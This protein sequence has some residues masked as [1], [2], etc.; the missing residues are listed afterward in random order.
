MWDI[1]SGCNVI[2]TFTVHISP[3][4]RPPQRVLL[5]VEPTDYLWF[6]HMSSWTRDETSMTCFQD[7]A[8]SSCLVGSDHGV[9]Q[10]PLLF[11]SENQKKCPWKQ[12]KLY[13]Q[14]LGYSRIF[15]QKMTTQRPNPD[16]R[17]L[18]GAVSIGAGYQLPG[19]RVQLWWPRHRS[20]GREKHKGLKVRGFSQLKM[21]IFH[22]YVSLPEGKYNK[23]WLVVWSMIFIFFHLLGISSSQL[24]NS[25]FS[26]G[27][28]PPT[29]FEFQ[30]IFSMGAKAIQLQLGQFAGAF[31]SWIR[32]DGA[33][34]LG[35]V[36]DGKVENGS[37]ANCQD[38][39]LLMTLLLDYYNPEVLKPGMVTRWVVQSM[40]LC[41]R[42]TC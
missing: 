34:R 4:L 12:Q 37:S 9:S 19:G 7:L 42:Y 2:V 8:L 10:N 41:K 35:F 40:L 27:L 20:T 23:C 30:L 28:K 15:G 17:T 16:T 11:Q 26:E 39:R 31:G 32:T 38:R 22:S 3:P 33:L 24:T 1:L 21:V 29:S 13:E 18:G 5:H 14:N 36:G 6:E 25:Y